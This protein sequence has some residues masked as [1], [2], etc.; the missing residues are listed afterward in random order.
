MEH[1]PEAPAPPDEVR[2]AECGTLL[3]EGQDRE[4]TEGGVFCRPCFNN[5]TEHLQQAINAQ[6]TDINYSMA[7]VGGLAGGAVGVLT[8][9]GFTVL[10]HVAFGLVGRKRSIRKEIEILRLAVPQTQRQGGAAIQH[11]MRRHRR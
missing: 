11:E 3:G 10:T 9:W 8:W 4:T 6:E 7:V 5:L 1:T 2:C